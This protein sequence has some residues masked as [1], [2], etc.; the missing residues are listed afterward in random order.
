MCLETAWC[1]SFEWSNKCELNPIPVYR[2]NGNRQCQCYSESV[3]PRARTAPD[4]G[5]IGIDVDDAD[6]VSP[7][8]ATVVVLAVVIVIASAGVVY[9]RKSAAAAGK[10]ADS[11]EWDDGA[12]EN[13]QEEGQSSADTLWI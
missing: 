8:A 9:R 2:T 11:M 1:R 7:I 10:L 13:T 4:H 12:F 5:S 6:A 3:Q